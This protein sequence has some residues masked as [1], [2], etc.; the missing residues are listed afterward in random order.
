[1]WGTGFVIGLWPYAYGFY[2][3]ALALDLELAKTFAKLFA[4]ALFNASPLYSVLA[5]YTYSLKINKIYMLYL[6]EVLY[7]HIF[8][9]FYIQP[10]TFV[11][12]Y[13]IRFST[14]LRWPSWHHWMQ[15]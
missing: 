11:Y 8:T 3:N 9:L 1:M 6:N 13:S 12:I 4:A 7:S 10:L 2:E 14:Y 15:Y 5:R